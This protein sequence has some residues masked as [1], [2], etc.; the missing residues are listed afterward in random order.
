MLWHIFRYLSLL[1]I[2]ALT[3]PLLA[4]QDVVVVEGDIMV[5]ANPK[6][7][8]MNTLTG[9]AIGSAS[10]SQLWP[11]GIIPYTVDPAL[12]A[13]SLKAINIA[14]QHWNL[15]GGISFLPMSIARERLPG[16]VVD[17]VRFVAGDY[18]ASWVGRRGGQQDLWIAPY[19]PAGS[20]M[21]EMGHVLG[22]EHEHTRPDRDQHIAIHWANIEP[23]KQHNFDAAPA[24][25]RL[26]GEY[27]HD[28]IMHYGTHNFSSN[29][30]AT[31][32]ALN[33]GSHRLGQRNAPSLGDLSAVASLYGS[34]LSL[35]AQ[36]GTSSAGPVLDIYVS[37]QHVQGAHDVSV[38]V[39][40]PVALN[41]VLPAQDDWQCSKSALSSLTC[42]L[43]LLQGSATTR[44][45]IGLADTISVSGIEV[46]LTSKTPDHDLSNNVSRVLSDDATSIAGERPIFSPALPI[47]DKPLLQDDVYVE[48]DT[49]GAASS[50]Q[51]LAMLLLLFV[52]KTCGRVN[53]RF[54]ANVFGKHR[55]YLLGRQIG[56][57]A[58]GSSG[59]AN[60]TGTVR[61][62]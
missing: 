21:H 8:S 15:V 31:I 19:C 29:G 49:R 27:D 58:G 9:R 10:S 33:G 17:S 20:V 26:L 4:T 25:T 12:P 5:P 52:G 50:L 47:E 24:G 48:V 23:G 56:I 30:Q 43:G 60:H 61:I 28:S 37:N 55:R 11:A 2:V 34:D 44:L 39:S 3:N 40:G 1:L 53:R 6:V 14:I 7:S 35:V 45:T 36:S 46:S 13:A 38:H 16:G 59:I 18:C 42:T 62:P 54:I 41:D 51:T 57:G 32:S 22:L